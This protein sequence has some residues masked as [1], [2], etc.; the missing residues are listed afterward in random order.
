[1]MPRCMHM[2]FSEMELAECKDLAQAM[3]EKMK[4]ELENQAKD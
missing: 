1:M 3:L 2:M 4:E